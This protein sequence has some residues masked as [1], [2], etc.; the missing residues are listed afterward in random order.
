MKSKKEMAEE[1]AEVMLGFAVGKN[2]QAAARFKTPEF[3]ED[4]SQPTWNWGVYNY[5]LKPRTIKELA[6]KYVDISLREQ[7][8][9]SVASMVH[10]GYLE[11]AKAQRELDE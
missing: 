11:G 10:T 1:M 8:S 6:N 5:R 9:Q 3:W 2:I 4:D 7:G